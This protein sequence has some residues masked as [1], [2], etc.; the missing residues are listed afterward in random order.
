W[1]LKEIVTAKPA[2]QV[3]S[4]EI[5]SG[6]RNDALF[7]L[8]A[9]MRQKG[10]SRA[11]I[12]AALLAENRTRCKPP[13][14]PGEVKTLASQAAKYEPSKETDPDSWRELFKNYSE[15]EETPF[16]W[17]VKDLI[18]LES[19]TALG[20]LSGHGK[21]LLAISLA[22]AIV[23]GQPFLNHFEIEVPRSVLY[24][25][26]EA[27]SRSFR[28][29]LRSFQ[30]TLG[31]DRFLYR[32]LS[33]GATIPLA[34]VRMLKAVS[35]RVVFLDTAIRFSQGDENSSTEN[36]KGLAQD[37]FKLLQ[38]GAISVIL[39]HHSP[40]SS[41][42]QDVMTLENVLRGSTDIGAMLS[43]VYGVRQ[44]DAARNRIHVECVKAR[45]IEPI[46]P[47]E[48]EGRPFID[49]EG[50]FRMLK[51]PG[52]CGWLADE[53]PTR[54]SKE[55]DAKDRIREWRGQ[56]VTGTNELKKRLQAAKLG[57]KDAVMRQWIHE[58]ENAGQVEIE[59]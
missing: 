58:V 26:P 23:L 25:I 14:S 6:Q 44:L 38:A 12:E 50:D 47:F 30:F 27:G 16:A 15:E 20:G 4:G 39:I 29:R 22:K 10:L 53:K 48:I 34:D 40:K 49:S 13:L 37:I 2:P 9:S 18:E 43:N 52:E 19:A 21:T 7:R 31:D 55:E 11:A 59:M 1:L 3:S 36:Q 46:G 24:L 8:G 28:K 56:G 5:P 57:A 32:T 54:K 35:G 45:D 41:Q 17:L 42:N 33:H 51:K